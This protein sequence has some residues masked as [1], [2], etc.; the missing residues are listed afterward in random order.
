M[1]FM[2]SL[3]MQSLFFPIQGSCKERTSVKP[4]T[5]FLYYVNI[6]AIYYLGRSLECV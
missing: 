3:Y 6:F 1:F 5:I 2:K 4:S